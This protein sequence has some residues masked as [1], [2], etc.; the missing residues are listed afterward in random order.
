MVEGIA[1]TATAGLDICVAFIAVLVLF[2]LYDANAL[3]EN[4]YVTCG[5]WKVV[6]LVAN[7]IS[8]AGLCMLCDRVNSA[9]YNKL[10]LLLLWMLL[11]LPPPL[12]WWR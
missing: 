1:V 11:M 8:E 6:A 7:G 9:L 3:F 4:Y 10:L 2:V 5:K 12:L